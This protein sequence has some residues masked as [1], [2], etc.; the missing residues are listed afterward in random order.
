ME[1]VNTY[2]TS[3]NFYLIANISEDFSILPDVRNQVFTILRMCP[4]QLQW[5]VQAG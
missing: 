3:V 4:T 5:P 1:A 2:E